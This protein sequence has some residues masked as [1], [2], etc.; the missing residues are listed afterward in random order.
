MEE[1]RNLDFLGYPDYRVFKNGIVQS[2]K[3]GYWKSLKA[4][5]DSNGY[6]HVCL[7]NKSH[8]TFL[9]HHL[10][11]YAF[12]GLKYSKILQCRH[13]D[14]NRLNNNL[15]NLCWGTA[16]ENGKDKIKHGTVKSQQGTNNSC[17]KLKE[18]DVLNIRR[19]YQTGKYTQLDLSK[20]FGT[21]D[22]NIQMILKRKSW[23]HI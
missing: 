23:T 4:T 22:R 1:Y 10:V 14:G 8:K 21:T 11:L 16:T 5:K 3:G 7:S 6:L 12:V 15:E 2:V 18:E 9:V 13:L 20:I 17:C 19:L